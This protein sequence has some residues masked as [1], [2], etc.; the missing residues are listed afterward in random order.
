[1]LTY[2]GVHNELVSLLLS[3]VTQNLSLTLDI[4]RMFAIP[5]GSYHTI[6]K[7][8]RSPTYTVSFDTAVILLNVLEE[9]LMMK[10]VNCRLVV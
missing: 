4:E 8:G 3:N 5:S 10:N 2:V 6:P 9:V 1:M 7:P